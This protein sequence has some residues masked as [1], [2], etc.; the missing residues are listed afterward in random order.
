MEGL[1]LIGTVHLDPDGHALLLAALGDLR[2][3]TVTVE[4]SRYALE[5]RRTLGRDLAGRLEPFRR[6]DGSLPRAMHA[7][8]AQLGFPFEYTAAE[9]YAERSGALVVPVGDGQ[10]SRQLLNRLE[11]ELMVTDNLVRLATRAEAPLAEQVEREW[12]RA[13]RSHR[14]GPTLDSEA[15]ARLDTINRRMARQIRAHAIDMPLVHVGGW[16][17]L[18]GLAGELSDLGPEVRLLRPYP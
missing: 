13:R 12:V 9:A 16:E 8:E 4:V 1:I 5:F 17:H 2:P 11:R 7:V 6:A 10:L 15:M 3:E 18:K 14:E